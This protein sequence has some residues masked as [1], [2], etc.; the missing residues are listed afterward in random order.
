M[1]DSKHFRVL[2]L[3]RTVTVEAVIEFMAYI[4]KTYWIE[5]EDREGKQKEYQ[6]ETEAK[7]DFFLFFFLEDTANGESKKS[8]RKSSCSSVFQ[9]SLYMP[10]NTVHCFSFLVAKTLFS[11]DFCDVPL[12]HSSQA[13]IWPFLDASAAEWAQLVM[14]P[15]PCV[16]FSV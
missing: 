7:M 5:V 13:Q 9:S 12:H 11:Q 14:L 4:T 15:Y 1:S 6:W 16:V 2:K 3:I 8:Q 10:C